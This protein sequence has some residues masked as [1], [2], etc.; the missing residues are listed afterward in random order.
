MGDGAPS[1]SIDTSV[2]HP[3]RI[4][5]AFLGGKDNFAVDRQIGEQTLALFPDIPVLARQ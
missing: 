2:P 1:P 4:Y 3:A 5:N